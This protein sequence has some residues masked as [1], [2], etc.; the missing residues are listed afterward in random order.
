MDSEESR[1][2]GFP[3]VTLQMRQRVQTHTVALILTLTYNQWEG[4]TKSRASAWL[5]VK[6]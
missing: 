3:A 1:V 5:T 4:N 6:Y 2:V